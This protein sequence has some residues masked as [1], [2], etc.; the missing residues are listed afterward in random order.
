MEIEE[1]TQD[2]LVIVALDGRVDGFSAPDLE[3]RI[4]EIVER[5]DTHVLLDCGKMNYISSA[6]LRAVLVGAKKCQQGGGKLTLCALQPACKSVMEISGFL[7]LLDHYE[8][9]DAALA[10]E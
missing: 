1:Q 4:S 7:T 9:R 3:K 5:G 10:A 2:S 6:G 8:T